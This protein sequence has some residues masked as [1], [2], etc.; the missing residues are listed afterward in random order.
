MARRKLP[1]AQGGLF[2]GTGEVLT[3]FQ[4]SD[5]QRAIFEWLLRGHGDAMVRAVAGS[6]KSTTLAEGARLVQTEQALFC[7]FNRHIAEA[8]R[9][10]LKGT[11]FSASTIHGVGYH[12]LAKNL[13]GKLDVQ[14][15]KYRELAKRYVDEAFPIEGK[16]SSEAL[17][18]RQVYVTNLARLIDVIRMTLTD[19]RDTPALQQLARQYGIILRDLMAAGVEQALAWGAAQATDKRLVDF[20][21][22]I[23]L[24][25]RLDL[26]MPQYDFVF[27]DECQDL[28][29]CQR[30]LVLRL[31]A[32]GGRYLFV[33]D[34]RQSIML[35]AGA[36]SHSY[37]RILEATGAVEFPLSVCYRC[38]TSH[39]ELA[40]EEVP[41]IEARPGAPVGTIASI[42]EQ[43]LPT[44]V[45]AG[46]LILCR[47]NA[48]LV[49]WCLEL[50]KNQ[51]Q[52]RVR[53][54]DV[55][56]EL[57]D[58]ARKIGSPYTSFVPRLQQHAIEQRRRLEEKDVSEATIQMH[59]DMCLALE[60][61]YHGFEEARSVEELCQAIDGL[62]SD[63]TAA[64]WFSTVHRAKG[65]QAARVFLLRP[66]K[67][68]LVW[69]DQ[70]IEEKQQEHNL[71]Y[72]ALTRAT[73][74]LVFLES[75]ETI[76][77]GK[78]ADRLEC[79]GA[80]L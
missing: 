56:R 17:A 55:A 23:Y 41:E 29:V 13:A 70:T 5:Y 26:P 22:L 48:P 15:R 72:V 53:G 19:A 77:S 76:A 14:D 49:G 51:V 69:T 3:G 24:P 18:Q 37:D 67:L 10:K 12:V 59:E 60:V 21:D 71:L 52:A 73:D 33:G 50:I 35:F 34:P 40:R 32:P 43:Q 64:I 62:F 2:D 1:A 75:A 25:L 79:Y 20:T 36:D 9:S 80:D 58:L 31:R 54:R 38:P 57:A 4:P 16:L 45:R 74:T 78:A 42:P 65:D 39:L 28:N 6:G 44:L 11:S 47:L 68:P 8:L 66:D 46:D 27:V 7:A 61:C 63:D 30:E